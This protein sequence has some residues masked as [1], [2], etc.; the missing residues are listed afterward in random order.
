MTV[1]EIILAIFGLLLVFF[2]PGY[3]LVKSLFPGRHALDKEYNTIY[4]ITL[5]MAMSIV[6]SILSG[7]ILGSLPTYSVIENGEEV[8]RGYFKPPYIQL[9]LIGFTLIFFVVAWYR[10]AFPW[11]GRLHKSMLRVPAAEKEEFK[12]SREEKIDEL[13]LEFRDLARKRE[14]LKK[15]IKDAGRKMKASS[16]S[17]RKH[18]KKKYQEKLKELEAIEDRIDELEEKRAEQIAEGEEG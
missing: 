17:M 7:F 14:K 9:N 12:K 10:G 8:Q 18:Y 16:E 15:E 3:M 2:L 1:I 4:V 5:A 6:I 13:V 11:M